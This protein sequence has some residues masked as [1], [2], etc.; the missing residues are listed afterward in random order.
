MKKNIRRVFW[1]YFAI[2]LM[3]VAYLG[4]FILI[5]SKNIVSSTYNPRL[6]RNDFSIKRGNIY[7]AG[8]SVLAM[9]MEDGAGYRRVFNY[10]ERYAHTVGFIHN[11]K[12]GVE[13]KYNFTLNNLSLGI[14]QRVWNLVN[15][16]P[17]QGDNVHLT[18]DPA[19]QNAAFDALGGNK[20]GIV[21]M[22]PATGR[23]I[24]MVS[25][26]YYDPNKIG[27]NW[28]NLSLDEKNSPLLNRA[29]QGLYPPGSI[30]KVITADAIME[31][32]P[33]YENYY[34]E[35]K[36]TAVFD[37]KQIQCYDGKAHG[38]INLTDAMKYSCNTYFASAAMEIGF[39]KISST[40][41]KAMFNTAYEFDLEY[42]SSRFDSK[43]FLERELTADE[44]MQ[45]AI[46]QGKTLVTPLH[47]AMTASAIAN[48][49][50]MMKPYICEKITSYMGK[51]KET[52]VPEELTQAFSKENADKLKEM[53][54]SVVEGGT[55]SAAKVSGI[56]IAGKTG[57]AENSSG[58][59]H[60][61]FIAMAPA[62]KPEIAIA[63]I[64]ENTNGTK[65]ALS[66]AK[67]L[68][69]VYFGK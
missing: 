43:S 54:V 50:V 26:P 6:N 11:T 48:G 14:S 38:T 25:A 56:S 47:M 64:T 4:K 68:V 17:L 22:E 16:Q 65:K 42:V 60:G 69:E 49:G 37:G 8:N 46:G 7:D 20:G 55:G 62:D 19:M 40:A 31:N 45:T 57:T 58:D 41:E 30:F 36:G 24:A 61:W 1:L 59:D 67:T 44:I 15:K 32:M 66:I 10:G 23:I 9:S 28:E 34:Y 2:F 53:M 3:V 35:C 52:A 29:T 13:A 21:V 33:D 51:E 39:D 63:I 12:A 5:D 27:E 18:L